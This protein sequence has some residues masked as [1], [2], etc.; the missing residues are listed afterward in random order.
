MFGK[1]NHLAIQLP[2]KP[3]PFD[4][5]GGARL[6]LLQKCPHGALQ[7]AKPDGTLI[8]VAQDHS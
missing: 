8:D 7:L 1:L 5:E 2:P 6:K 4:D 3:I